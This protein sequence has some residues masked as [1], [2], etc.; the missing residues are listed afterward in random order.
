MSSF[1]RVHSPAV[2]IGESRRDS[3]SPLTSREVSS[4]SAE[5]SP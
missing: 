1:G 4:L 2:E 5:P 3:Q